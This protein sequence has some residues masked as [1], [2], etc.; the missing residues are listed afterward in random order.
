MLNLWNQMKLKTQKA[1]NYN[2]LLPS[3]MTFIYAFQIAKLTTLNEWKIKN[4]SV[5]NGVKIN[6]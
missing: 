2:K 1:E 4:K 5:K 6:M 3:A